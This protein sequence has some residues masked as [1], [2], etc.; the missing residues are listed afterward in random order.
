MP[1]KDSMLTTNCVKW[2]VCF[3]VSLGVLQ[4]LYVRA[5]LHI[6]LNNVAIYLIMSSKMILLYN[7][8]YKNVTFLRYILFWLKSVS[9]NY[10]W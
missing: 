5:V 2:Y 4:Y 1:I 9:N 7:M 10:L 6:E 3:N 8:V